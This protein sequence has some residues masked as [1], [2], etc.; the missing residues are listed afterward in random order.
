M[1]GDSECA[2]RDRASPEEV[3]W[4]LIAAAIFARDRALAGHVPREVVCEHRS[5]RRLLAA[6]V[7]AILVVMKVAD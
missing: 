6:G 1:N 5:C 2:V 7:E 4:H 3:A